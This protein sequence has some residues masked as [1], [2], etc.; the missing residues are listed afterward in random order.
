MEHK[1]YFF[2]LIKGRKETKDKM[3]S[4]LVYL[5]YTIEVSKKKL[6]FISGRDVRSQDDGMEA[7]VLRSWQF[8]GAS[9]L[10]VIRLY[11]KR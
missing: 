5:T 7:W 3:L 9:A 2:L 11:I 1:R 6:S 10:V 4:L 8:L